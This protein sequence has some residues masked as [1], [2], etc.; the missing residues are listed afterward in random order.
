VQHERGNS[1]GQGI[2]STLVFW[3]SAAYRKAAAAVASGSKRK[4]LHQSLLQPV[5]LTW[6]FLLWGIIIIACYAIGINQLAAISGPIAT[7][8]MVGLR[9]SLVHTSDEPSNTQAA[10]QL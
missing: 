3:Q 7:F 1:F 4:C 10:Q 8:N 6:P 9:A 2:M 5:L